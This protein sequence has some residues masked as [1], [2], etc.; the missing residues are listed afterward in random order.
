MNS[1]ED[2]VGLFGLANNVVT[3]LDYEVLPANYATQDARVL[4]FHRTEWP[5]TFLLSWAD[6]SGVAE[7]RGRV[8][9]LGPIEHPSRRAAGI[10]AP[11]VRTRLQPQSR[12][13]T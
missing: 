2:Y 4:H 7:L 9:V 3:L 13:I 10:A 12:C 5:D 1:A 6:Q 8:Y 11:T